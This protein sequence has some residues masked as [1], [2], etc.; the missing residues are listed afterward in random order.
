MKNLDKVSRI[1]VQAF[2]NALRLHRDSIVLHKNTSFPSAYLL[3]VLAQE[4]IGKAF[5]MENHVFQMYGRKEDIDDELIKIMMNVLHDHKAK[6]RWFAYHEGGGYP[7]P[8]KISK[9]T[10]ESWNGQIEVKKQIA[11]YVGLVNRNPSG[12]I[13]SPMKRI[14]LNDSM[15]QITRVNDFVIELAE[16]C[17]R[18][19]YSVDTEEVDNLLSIKLVQDLEALW[20]YKTARSERTLKKIRK[21]KVETTQ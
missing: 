13:S 17:R 2:I 16:G 12:K 18:E 7:I 5:L 10:K 20:P 19:I 4:E 14:R 3:S 15:S 8:G 6:Q 11:T 9:F 1:A 21:Y